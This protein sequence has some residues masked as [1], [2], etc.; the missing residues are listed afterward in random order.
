M[1]GT[2]IKIAAQ[3]HEK[4]TDKGDVA[5]ALHPIEVMLIVKQGIWAVSEHM[6]ETVLA[7]AVLHDALEDFDGD[8]A[9]KGM[10]E[11]DLYTL[12]GSRG[13]SALQALTRWNEESYED[14][15]ERVSRDWIARL[16]KIADLTHNMNVGRLPE[17]EI[18]EKDFQRWDKYRR[19]LVRLERE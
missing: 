2:A 11:D 6:R 19:A 12:L 7:V 9:S 10:L 13:W 5:Y 18:G 4:Q 16:V 8:P 15:I 1:L 14:Y 17:L 3:V